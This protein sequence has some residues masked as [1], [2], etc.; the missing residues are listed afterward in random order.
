M[1]RKGTLY[2]VNFSGNHDPGQ[3][4]LR[5]CLVV[6]NDVLNESR[7]NTTV[8]IVVTSIPEFGKLPGNVVLNKGVAQMPW[9]GVINVSQIMSIE[10]RRIEKEIGALP[11]DLMQKVCAGLRLIMA[12]A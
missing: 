12:L 8:V 5:P 4:E 10:K 2:W 7:L 1:I 3:K 9:Q 11:D 6:Q